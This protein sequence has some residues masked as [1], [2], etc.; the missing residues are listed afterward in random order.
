M[1]EH[2]K[3]EEFCALAAAGQISVG[4]MAELQTH[5][6]ECCRCKELHEDFRDISSIWLTQ[7]QELEPEMYGRRLILRN[8]IL[9]TLQDAGAQF[10]EPLRNQ[11]ATPPKRFRYFAVL[12]SPAPLWAAA[13]LVLFAAFLGF[14]I[15]TR[16]HV[17]KENTSNAAIRSVDLP[18]PQ[19][20]DAGF[21]SKA[22]SDASP[23]QNSQKDLG[24]RLAASE[25]ERAKALTDIQLLRQDIAELQNSRDK[26]A[27][28]I[29][30]LKAHS[31]QD[32][33]VA[34]SAQA[35]I[36]SLKE[37]E[38][39][40]NADMVATEIQLRDLEG[41]LAD[42]RA[43]AEKDRALTELSSSS[44][45]RDVI[46]SRNL[47]IIDVADVAN[48]GV[49]KPFGRIFYTEGKSLI[50]YAYDLA[51]AKGTKTFYAWG[52]R[53][54]DT[55]STRALGSLRLDD[56]AQ[57]RWVFKSNDAKVLAQIDS[58][59]VTLEPTAKPG[60]KPKGQKILTAFLGTQA[61]HP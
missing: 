48:S 5:L 59:Y 4:E 31:E 34:I 50:F 39:S 23:G 16:K 24:Q 33:S 52:H 19:P 25:S 42:Q 30:E 17:S 18:T 51:G 60:D 6:Q 1:L 53:E 44:E 20:H 54:G 28:Q 11:L 61:N 58:V 47:H 35:Q 29:A 15:G 21:D 40:K 46:A 8:K 37:A 26:D 38:D 13:A 22:Q 43:S 56:P 7:A 36:R 14:E 3:Y 49:Q 57:G 41:K 2:T 45:M 12:Q 10:S 9:E 27:Q 55:N 32:Q